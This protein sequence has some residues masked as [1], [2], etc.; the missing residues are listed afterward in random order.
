[1]TLMSMIVARRAT[2]TALRR[3][4]ST[5]NGAPSYRDGAVS[6]PSVGGVGGGGQL[7]PGTDVGAT[8]GDIDSVS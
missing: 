1:M 6:A 5:R 8:R 7:G 4:D 2:K 3:P